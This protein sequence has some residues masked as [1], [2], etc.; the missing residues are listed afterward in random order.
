[1]TIVDAAKKRYSTKVFDPS[2]KLTDDQLQQI[3]ALI[4]LS[5][6]S[7]N[8][9]P[10]HVIVA[11]T[12][13]SKQ[14]I[15]KAAEGPYVF[16]KPKMLDAS[17]VLVFCSKIAIDDD[18]LNDLL[19]AEQQDGR[20][21]NEQSKQRM[22]D[23]RTFFVDLHRKSLGDADQWMQKQV[24]LNIGSLLLGVAAM[25]IDAVPI[26]GF[27][28]DILDEEFNL[29]PQGFTSLVVVPVGYHSADDFNANVPKSRWHDEQIFTEC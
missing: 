18:Y 13:D 20:F 4:R 23:G 21:S 15:A 16:N 14:R 1:M 12:D 3:K 24:Y 19:A 11:A 26:E 22:I 2:R 29:S 6:S 7:V 28:R 17:H 25:G 8:S 10:W 27:D 5:A 9:Q